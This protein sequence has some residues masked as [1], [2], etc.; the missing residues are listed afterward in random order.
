MPNS[1]LPEHVVITEAL[2]ELDEQLPPL[3]AEE[4]PVELNI[5]G[6]YALIIREVRPNAAEL[7]DIDYIGSD[8]P[9]EWRAAIDRIG[10]ARGLGRGWVN[11]DVQLSGAS[12]EDM[13]MATGPLEFEPYDANLSHFTVNIATEATLLRMKLIAIDTS[14][15]AVQHG[16]DFTRAR[17]FEDLPRFEARQP[18]AVRRMVAELEEDALLLDSDNTRQAASLA[19]RGVPASNILSQLGLSADDDNRPSVTNSSPTRDSRTYP[20][21]ETALRRRA[22]NM[23][24]NAQSVDDADFD[25]EPDDYY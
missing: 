5:V 6:G 13:E 15:T 11:N 22:K 21:S 23:L 20:P 18:G 4:K 10:M 19:S 2:R 17:D 9:P 12:L 7:T 24:K 1:T 8:L 3:S 16:G 25:T 14:L